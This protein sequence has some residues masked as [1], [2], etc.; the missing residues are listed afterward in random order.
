MNKNIFALAALVSGLL[1]YCPEVSANEGFTDFIN[2]IECEPMYEAPLEEIPPTY[3][4][5]DTEVDLL[6]KVSSLEGGSWDQDGM[7]H[8]MQVVL[9]RVEDE[10]FPNSITEV[11]FEPGQFTTAERLNQ[12]TITPE[13]YAALDCVIFGDYVFNDCLYFE[14]AE[15]IIWANCHDYQFSYGG[16]DFYKQ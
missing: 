2:S 8:V 10:R 4:L 16:H 13:A 5:T 6:L 9:N 1:F 14:S 11:I 7:A 3:I 12:A 15:G